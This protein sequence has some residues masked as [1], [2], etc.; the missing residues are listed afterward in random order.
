MQDDRRGGA[1][2]GLWNRSRRRPLS[3]PPTGPVDP[4]AP[5]APNAPGGD[6]G[7]PSK[8]FR[9]QQ[10]PQRARRRLGRVITTGPC[11]NA[12]GGLSH[13]TRG[14]HSE[15]YSEGGFEDVE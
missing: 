6:T 10:H 8:M 2:A 1:G 7:S 12:L 14:T 9:Q 5:S 4:I 11:P 13:H 3:P 15:A